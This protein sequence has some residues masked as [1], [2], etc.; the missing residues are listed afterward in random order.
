[1]SLDADGNVYRKRWDGQYR[2]EQG[3]FGPKKDK[4]IWGA[5]NVE[6]DVL[7]QP[8]PERDFWGKQRTSASG[9]P[10]YKARRSGGSGGSGGSFFGGLYF[11]EWDAFI[12][13]MLFSI[14]FAFILVFLW[15]RLCF[16]YP[17]VM[18]PLSALALIGAL[19][20]GTVTNKAPAATPGYPATAQTLGTS[21]T[22]QASTRSA[23]HTNTRNTT[24]GQAHGET[25]QT[26]A[27][28]PTA[29]PVKRSAP[30]RVAAPAPAPVGAA[31]QRALFYVNA[32]GHDFTGVNVHAG[33]GLHSRIL[34]VAY[35]GTRLL[36]L[37][38]PTARGSDGLRWRWVIYHHAAGY[39]RADLLTPQAPRPL[40]ARFVDALPQGFTG[41]NLR[42]GPG[43][44][45]PILAIVYNGTRVQAV[46]GPAVPGDGLRWARVVYAR[47]VGYVRA[48]LLSPQKPQ[49]L[50]ARFVD[51]MAQ[52]FTGVNLRERAGMVAPIEV[53]IPNRARVQVSPTPL[54][55]ADGYQWY[56]VVYRQWVGYARA[57]FLQ[58]Q[59]PAPVVT[60]R[61]AGAARGFTG[62]NLRPRPSAQ[63]PILALI[64]NGAR[65]QVTGV[66]QGDD[67]QN[68]SR[69]RYQGRSG[70]AHSALLV[71]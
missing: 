57:A 67:G 12:K 3:L 71:P 35:N 46:D 5:P 41:V 18:L 40:L 10:L 50:A 27:A 38:L 64:P 36:G 16:R 70:Y 9:R 17:K 28:P 34:A 24:T 63:A 58:R 69:V 1:M 13:V 62:A 52:G 20:Y 7:G 42:V 23:P 51:A 56:R 53:L 4:T 6:R 8:E 25:G 44:R 68:W 15:L 47:K 55:G 31:D 49:P 26:A 65:V 45:S 2:E 32:L 11:G 33:P 61:V 66:V 22:G 59:M 60:L 21:A 19:I 39:V 30:A 43:L 37:G 14:L 54:R 29:V 48:D